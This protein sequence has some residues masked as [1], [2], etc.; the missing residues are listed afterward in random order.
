MMGALGAHG[1]FW[2]N[3]DLLMVTMRGCVKETIRP[4]AFGTSPLSMTY[5]HE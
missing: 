4:A 3:V 1:K 2:F 5:A